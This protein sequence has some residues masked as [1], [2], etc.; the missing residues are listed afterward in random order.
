[1]MPSLESLLFGV[2]RSIVPTDSNGIEQ[3]GIIPDVVISEMHSDEIEVTEHPVDTGANI[4][5]HAYKKP[6]ECVCTF[7]WSDNSRAVNSLLDGSIFRGIENINDIYNKLLEIHEKRLPVKLTT[8]KR[9]YPQ[10]LIKQ[11]KTVTDKDTENA[12]LIEV[13]FRELLVAQAKTVSLASVRQKNPRRTAGTTN[14]GAVHTSAQQ[15][16]LRGE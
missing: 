5:D 3:Q 6:S 8:A 4:S 11:L 12:L 16:L 14:R 1:M 2:K 7:G 9:V 10:M 13:T 15:K